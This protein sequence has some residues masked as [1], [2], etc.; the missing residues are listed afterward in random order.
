MCGTEQSHEAGDYKVDDFNRAGMEAA[1]NDPLPLLWKHP[2]RFNY[3]QQDNIEE[4]PGLRDDV[5]SEDPDPNFYKNF[6]KSERSI[7]A[8]TRAKTRRK[9]Y[10]KDG[11]D[12]TMLVGADPYLKDNDILKDLKGLLRFDQHFGNVRFDDWYNNST[13]RALIC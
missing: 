8:L 10:W 3:Q 13:N 7:V 4:E 12:G 9:S 2:T 5:E 6:T 1:Q 11:T